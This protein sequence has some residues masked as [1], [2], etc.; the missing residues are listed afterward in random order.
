MSQDYLTRIQNTI[1][2]WE[3][4]EELKKERDKI[5]KLREKNMESCNHEIVLT[6]GEKIDER[7][8]GPFQKYYCVFCKKL[9][10]QYLRSSNINNTKQA[11]VISFENQLS[12]YSEV[13]DVLSLIQEKLEEYLIKNR[14]A[15]E[16]DIEN[17]LYS[18]NLKEF[19]PKVK[20]I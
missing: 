19:G 17:Y 8:F 1:N 2:Y 16:E 14:D 5:F 3:R 12:D 18:I 4:L 15:K 6:F 11:L 13:R 20:R 7:V 9:I 10:K